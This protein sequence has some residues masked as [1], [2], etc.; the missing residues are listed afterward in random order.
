MKEIAE[1]LK[2][3]KRTGDS[4]V[5]TQEGLKV[6]EVVA[7]PG[8]NPEHLSAYQ[9]EAFLLTLPQVDLPI[10]HHFTEGLYARDMMIPAGVAL[11]GAV[12]RGDSFFMIRSGVLAILTPHGPELVAPGFMHPTKAGAKRAGY[13]VTDVICTTFHANPTN[14]TDPVALWDMLTVPPPEGICEIVEKAYLSARGRETG[15]VLE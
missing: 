6:S 1:T 7:V 8:L 5:S 14:E 12:H 9:F 4:P 11:T 10:V 2:E 15:R 3:V 13:A